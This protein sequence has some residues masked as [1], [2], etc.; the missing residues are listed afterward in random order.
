M[1]ADIFT[2]AVVAG[3]PL[4]L[5]VLGVVQFIKGFGLEGNVVKAISLFVGLV[6][7]IGYQL[8]LV[9]PVDFAG[10]FST[11]IFGLTLGLVAS[12]VYEVVNQ[13]VK[14]VP[15]QQPTF[16]NMYNPPKASVRSMF[17]PD[18]EP[19]YEDL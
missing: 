6:L 12:G 16:R 8:S 2:N 19:E 5:V 11:V 17:E 1:I 18:N 7:G 14:T 15:A 9:V 4:V 3:I 13:P 10:W